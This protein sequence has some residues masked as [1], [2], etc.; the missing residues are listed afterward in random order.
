M[1]VSRVGSGAGVLPGEG[2]EPE[3]QRD[4][5][6]KQGVVRPSQT[7]AW[8]L[9]RHRHKVSEIRK[10]GTD[11]VDAYRCDRMMQGRMREA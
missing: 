10:Q 5:F 1:T 6:R 4:G 8:G 7:A 9:T 2:A 11:G 3:R